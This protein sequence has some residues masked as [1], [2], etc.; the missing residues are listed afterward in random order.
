LAAAKG[1]L[2]ALGNLWEGA[3]EELTQQESSKKFLL[4]KRNKERKAWHVVTKI[5]SVR[6]LKKLWERAKERHTMDETKQTL[7]LAK[8]LM[9]RTAWHGASETKNTELLDILW[10]LGKE[11]LTTEELSNKLLL[12]KDNKQKKPLTRGRNCG[13]HRVIRENM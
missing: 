7:S 3:N 13:Q 12:A 4:T 11:E 5:C 10:E 6:V 8:H 1:K 2:E 9:R